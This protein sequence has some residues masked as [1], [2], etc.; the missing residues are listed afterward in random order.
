LAKHLKAKGDSEAGTWRLRWVTVWPLI[1]LVSAKHITHQE[2][3]E[4]TFYYGF[5]FLFHS[6]FNQFYHSFYGLNQVFF[7]NG[8]SPFLGDMVFVISSPSILRFLGALGY[9]PMDPQDDQ[10]EDF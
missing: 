7:F 5:D 10:P 9:G 4:C 8:F 1:G 3:I 6:F 2:A